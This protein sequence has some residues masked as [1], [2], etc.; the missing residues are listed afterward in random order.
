MALRHLAAIDVHAHTIVP[1]VE[2]LV[3]QQEGWQREVAQRNVTVGAQSLEHNR[4]RFA[5][6]YQQRFA[7]VETRLADMDAMGI[8]LQAVSI[9]PSFSYNYWADRALAERIVTMTNRGIAAFCAQRP[10]RF[11]GLGTVALQHPDLAPAQLEQAIGELGLKGVIISTSVNGVDLADLRFEPFWAK[12]EEL[13]AVVF[14]HPIGCALEMRLAPY[15]LS[16]VLGNPL[17]TTVAL[18]HLIFAGTLDRHPGLKLLA[19]HG[20]GFLPFYSGRFD[21]GWRV[22]PEAHTARQ[23]PS[24][25]LRRIWF[26]SIVFAPEILGFLIRQVGASQVMLGTDYPMDMGTD[27]PVDLLRQVHGLSASEIAAIAADNAKRLLGLE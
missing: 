27:R 1:E 20:G 26:D 6:T 21:H 14:I 13:G 18:S 3:R 23:M 11:A 19:A 8:D 4:R 2:A 25:Y 16:N 12:A 10:D 22:R 17:E 7:D 24:E 9:A 5:D 15:Y